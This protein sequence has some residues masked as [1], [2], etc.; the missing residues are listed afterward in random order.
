M[1]QSTRPD[2]VAGPLLGPADEQRRAGLRRMRLVATGLLGLAAVIFVLTL[3]RDGFWGYV[4]AASEAAMV[5]AVA[6]WFAV[7]ALF[8]HPLGLKVPHTALI[9]RKK[10]QLGASLEDFVTEN[11]LTP[12]LVQER[13]AQ[14][15]VTLRLGEWLRQPENADRV[16]QEVAPTLAHAVGSVRDDEVRTLLENFLLPRL[17]REPISPVAGSLLEGVVEDGSH[18]GLVDIATR[19]LHTWASANKAVIAGIIGERAPWWSPK[20]LDDTVIDRMYVE[21][22]SWLTD[23]RDQP[24]HPA[25]RA[26]DDLLRQLAQDL[27]HDPSTMQRAEQL[28]ARLLLHP[29]VADGMLSLWGSVQRTVVDAL[30]DPDGPLRTRLAVILAD[31]GDRVVRDADLRDSLERRLSD[32]VGYVVQTHGREISTLISQTVARW[33]GDEA[34]RRIELQVGRDLQFIRING[35]VVGGLVGLVIHALTQLA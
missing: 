11:F 10:D 35:T 16:V 19:E 20:W 26:L 17:A 30:G 7:T 29:G 32:A 13:L 28:K 27:Q 12:E 4:N 3:D 18:H 8:R 24:Q 34:A 23:V 31:L 33:D 9:P 2:A 15:D 21:I 5:G 25:R 1:T 14:A 6:D 22:M